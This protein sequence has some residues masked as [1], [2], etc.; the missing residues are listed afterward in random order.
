MGWGRGL[1]LSC[2]NT[3]WSKGIGDGGN[4][5]QSKSEF[6]IFFKHVNQTNLFSRSLILCFGGHTFTA[7][8]KS[9]FGRN[10]PQYHLTANPVITVDEE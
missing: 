7:G 2:M 3:V 10:L 4:A 9:C 5:T 6:A 8:L 1:R